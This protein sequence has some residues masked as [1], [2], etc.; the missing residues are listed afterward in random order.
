MA[1]RLKE[2][3]VK[4][5]YERLN[6]VRQIEGQLSAIA[7]PTGKGPLESVSKLA[8]GVEQ[9]RL[10]HERLAVA[11]NNIK[12]TNIA[13]GKPIKESDKDDIDAAILSLLRVCN[14]V[15]CMTVCTQTAE[16]QNGTKTNGTK[17]NGA[18]SHG[19]C[20]QG[21]AEVR[22]NNGDCW[23]GAYLDGYYHTQDG[24]N[25]QCYHSTY[26]N[27]TE[28][29][30]V[31]CWDGTHNNGTNSHSTNSNAVC[32]NVAMTNG[33]NSNEYYD[34]AQITY[35]NKNHYTETEALARVQ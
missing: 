25:N 27:G 34:P 8:L 19:T 29:N 6:F 32:A 33:G 26:A 9:T 14:N 1:Q 3:E 15:A 7:Y 23:N 20:W 24:Y 22:N 2:S 16:Y 17:S 35:S 11:D 31:A 4:A 10:E 13:A 12:S 28:G 30:G 18:C 5:W 21:T